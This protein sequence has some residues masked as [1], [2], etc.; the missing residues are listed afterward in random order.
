VTANRR[1][2]WR[3]TTP[4]VAALAAAGLTGCSSES[5]APGSSHVEAYAAV[6][7][8]TANPGDT[9]ALVGDAHGKVRRPVT[10]GTLPSALALV[11]GAAD[12][13]VTVKAQNELVEVATATGK[14]VGRIGVGLEPDA[15]AVTPDGTTALVA[16]FGDNT[17]TEIHLPALTGGR[18]VHVGGQPV[19]IALTPDGHQALVANFK[20]GT[21][22]PVALPSLASGAPVSVGAGP[23]AVSVPSASQAIVADFQTS[24]ITP[25]A[26]PSLVPSPSIPLGANP[27]G[28][29]S[30]PA[31]TVTWVSAGYGIT[32]VTFVGGVVGRPISLGVPAECIAVTQRGQAWVCGGNATLIEVDLASG[33]V[34]R[35][36]AVGGIP[37]AAVVADTGSS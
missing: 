2:A 13:L 34:L 27:T 6:G 19:S 14:V 10:V 21:L 32:P 23:V 24:S 36:V 37:A 31:G 33:R 18:T 28:I 12:L 20:D 22:T 9:V 16:N 11:P 5:A 26:L 15:V 25:V 7:A 8:N 30:G 35:T 1:L 3:L 4:V 17:V 29:A